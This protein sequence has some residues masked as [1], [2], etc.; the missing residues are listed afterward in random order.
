MRLNST[1]II[2]DNSLS[3]LGSCEN[4][5]WPNNIRAMLLF[6]DGRPHKI[7]LPSNWLKIAILEYMGYRI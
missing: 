4:Y 2:P 6:M 5:F 1:L 3:D 7:I